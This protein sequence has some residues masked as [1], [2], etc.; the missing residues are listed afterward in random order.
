MAAS[1]NEPTASNSP[2]AHTPD[3]VRSESPETDAIEQARR[4]LAASPEGHPDQYVL[5]NALGAHL[6]ARYGETKE[7]PLLQECISVHDQM[8]GFPLS[9]YL[10]DRARVM[11]NLTNFF[12]AWITSRADG[13]AA[14]LERSISLGKSVLAVIP[15]AHPAR[16]GTCYG[17]SELIVMRARLAGGAHLFGEAILLNR[18][19][20]SLRPTDHADRPRMHTNLA[21]ALTDL[22][23]SEGD[24]ALIDEAISYKG[25]IMDHRPVGH[26]ERGHMAAWLALALKARF[27]HSGE[28]HVLDEAIALERHALTLQPVGDPERVATCSGLGVSLLTRFRIAGDASCLDEAIKMHRESLYLCPEGLPERSKTYSSLAASLHTRFEH[29]GDD[30]A[31]IEAIAMSRQAL[32]IS[33]DDS[34]RA[35]T[36]SNLSNMLSDLFG[37]DNNVTHLEESVAV[38]REAIRLVGH[39]DRSRAYMNLS[40]ALIKL[41]NHTKATAVLDEAIDTSRQ[42]LQAQPGGHRDRAMSCSNL[43]AMLVTRFEKNGDMAL[44]VEAEALLDEALRLPPSDHLTHQYAFLAL[45]D[46]CIKPQFG[47]KRINEAVKHLCRAIS[48]DAED[49][50]NLL[51]SA[52]K[53][54]Q[55]L[56]GREVDRDSQEALLHAYSVAIDIASFVTGYALDRSAQLQNLSVCRTLGPDAFYYAQTLGDLEL[57]VQLL[58]GARGIVWS[59]LLQM[60]DPQLENVPAELASELTGLLRQL[61]ALGQTKSSEVSDAV[62]SMLD[63]DIRHRHNNRVQQII[64]QIRTIPNMSDFMRRPSF[65]RLQAAASTHPVVLLVAVKQQC[66]ALVMRPPPGP[67][68][69][70][71]LSGITPSDVEGLVLGLS[72]AQSHMRGADPYTEATVRIGVKVSR[73]LPPYDRM[74]AMLWKHV[75]KPVIRSLGLSVS[76]GTQASYAACLT[77]S[78]KASGRARSRIHWC[79]TGVFSFA[80]VHAAG[81]YAGS[82]QECCSDYAVSSYTP[83]LG[84]LLRTRTATTSMETRGLRLALISAERAQDTSLPVLWKV[85]AEIDAVAE[86]VSQAHAV[87]DVLDTPDSTTVAQV[88]ASFK[89]APLVHVACHGVQNSQKPLESGFCLRDGTLTVQKLMDLDL[90]NAFSAFLSACE[91]AKGDRAQ[92]DQTIHL[93]A[94]MLFAGFKSVVATMW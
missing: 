38:A 61:S 13:F 54:L 36:S 43:A 86:I 45:Y 91:T 90:K 49:L 59:Q 46:L 92:P 22:Y 26:A 23:K 11:Q 12:D 18:E 30:L 29:T 47:D 63:Q 65:E 5:C 31:L 19:A 83:T 33:S 58:E 80:P 60:R 81:I 73:T 20:L 41:Y 21:T 17:L 70:L 48:D 62:N 51:S 87:P 74:L 25:E 40:A 8:L 55:E 76:M 75:V 88:A 79:P 77:S 85:K 69:C 16:A 94:S 84:A 78:Q 9:E 1:T 68:V 57:G 14:A 89:I 72:N 52:G 53:R 27:R 67:L 2:L 3:V 32:L 56:M 50:P 39:V 35:A 10:D 64:R 4:A 6:W 7:V 71:A 93:A 15:Q 34:D 37:R 44:V 82:D 24:I 28:A 66:Y 42:A